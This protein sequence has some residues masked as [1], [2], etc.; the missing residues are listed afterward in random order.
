MC[1]PGEPWRP[2]CRCREAQPLFWRRAGLDAARRPLGPLRTRLPEEPQTRK[3]CW[4]ASHAQAARAEGDGDRV[5]LHTAQDRSRDRSRCAG[6]RCR[7]HRSTEKSTPQPWGSREMR[8]S[9]GG[10]K[11]LIH[12][13][14]WGACSCLHVNVKP[15]CPPTGGWINKVW[16]IHS[17]QLSDQKERTTDTR[18]NVDASQ[19]CMLCEIS[20]AEKNTCSRVPSIR[21]QKTQA[22]LQRQNADDWL[23]RGARWGWA[24]RPQK[25]SD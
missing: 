21:F 23:G 1:T 3:A 5:R 6:S 24:R 8:G 7:T 14:E 11:N 17:L 25:G 10:E 12:F 22:N 9:L 20:Q 19:K 15:K 16:Y 2:P 4:P 13:T 18:N